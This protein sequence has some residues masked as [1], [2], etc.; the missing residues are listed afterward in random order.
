V[1]VLDESSIG[2]IRQTL[3]GRDIL[4]ENWWYWTLCLFTNH[5][6]FRKYQLAPLLLIS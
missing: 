3:R 5:T 1:L 6:G 2:I 4:H